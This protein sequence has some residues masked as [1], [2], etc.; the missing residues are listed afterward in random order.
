[1]FISL[2]DINNL[3]ILETKVLKKHISITF[4]FEG[5]GDCSDFIFF[6]PPTGLEVEV[7]SRKK[8]AVKKYANWYM[9]Y[10]AEMGAILNFFKFL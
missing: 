8:Y 6:M 3:K 7:M 9:I 1:M 2:L 10:V 5:W 4:M